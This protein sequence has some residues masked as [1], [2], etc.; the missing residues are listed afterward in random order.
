[1]NIKKRKATGVLG[2]ML[3]HIDKKSLEM[4]RLEMEI[5]AMINKSINN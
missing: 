4:T 2:K 1:M 5:E 3:K